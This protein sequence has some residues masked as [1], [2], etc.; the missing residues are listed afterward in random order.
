MTRVLAPSLPD[1]L[2]I[3]LNR[4]RSRTVALCGSGRVR[5]EA[6]MKEIERRA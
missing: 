4:L 2:R 6:R 3:E 5:Q 1:K